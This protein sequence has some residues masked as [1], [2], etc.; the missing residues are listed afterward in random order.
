MLD[1]GAMSGVLGRKVLGKHCAVKTGA[2]VS[3]TRDWRLQH[4]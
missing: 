3:P 4:S 2:V 1:F